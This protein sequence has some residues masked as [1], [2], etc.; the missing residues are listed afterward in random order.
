MKRCSICGS[1]GATT[2]SP[3]GRWCCAR[4]NDIGHPAKAPAPPAELPGAPPSERTRTRMLE[5][6]RTERD[7]VRPVVSLLLGC[8]SGM[9]IGWGLGV[10]WVTRSA[11]TFVAGEER[12]REMSDE[13][14][15]PLL[16]TIRPPARRLP[17]GES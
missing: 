15:R 3:N 7:V 6:S 5:A 13:E 12:T 14:L 4:C 2:P 8:L 16:D 1:P 9:L 10:R 17:P 11:S